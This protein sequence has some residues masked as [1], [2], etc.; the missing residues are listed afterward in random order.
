M[1]SHWDLSSIVSSQSLATYWKVW[2]ASEVLRA[3]DLNC[4]WH[5]IVINGPSLRSSQTIRIERQIWLVIPPCLHLKA[6]TVWE[7]REERGGHSRV[8]FNPKRTLKRKD[9]RSPK[10]ARSRRTR[11][12][13]ASSW[14]KDV[15]SLVRLP[16]LCS[17]QYVSGLSPY[18]TLCLTAK[19]RQVTSSRTSSRKTVDQYVA[20]RDAAVQQ[21]QEIFGSQVP[22][23]E[24][25]SAIERAGN[26][27]H[28]D[29]VEKATAELL[30]RLSL[31]AQS[32]AANMSPKQQ[33]E[34]QGIPYS[35]HLVANHQLGQ[36]NNAI[37]WSHLISGLW[38]S[39]LQGRALS[40]RSWVFGISCL[41]S[42]RSAYGL[43]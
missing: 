28:C 10:M 21:L 31:K 25:Q 4:H 14:K 20:G 43:S 30:D 11:V 1:F 34:M 27:S 6:W 22:L 18:L 35:F 40:A 5:D 32:S 24:L 26:C 2:W 41:M 37:F 19:S 12:P 8:C 36:S 17:L 13:E 38:N 29:M 9:L 33:Q 7:G 39:Y 16:N 3:T 23:L 15:Q 42:F